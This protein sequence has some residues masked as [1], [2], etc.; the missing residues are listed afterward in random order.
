MRDLALTVG[1]H[2]SRI[3]AKTLE[4]SKSIGEHNYL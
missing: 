4:S 1:S 2:Q 3:T